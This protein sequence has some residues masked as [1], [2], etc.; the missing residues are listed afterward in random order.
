MQQP[1]AEL[2]Y[3][4]TP[5]DGPS[6]EDSTNQRRPHGPDQPRR[7]LPPHKSLALALLG[8]LSLGIVRR[9]LLEIGHPVLGVPSA[10]LLDLS[11]RPPVVY[12]GGPVASS[13]TARSA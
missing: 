5:G 11:D 10:A 7:P 1:T 9:R 4:Y 13:G 12:A 8:D 3:Q 2:P 6:S